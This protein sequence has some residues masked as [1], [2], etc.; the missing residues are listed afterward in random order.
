MQKQMG[1]KVLRC[2]SGHT[3]GC[4]NIVRF[5]R[6]GNTAR[7]DAMVFQLFCRFSNAPLKIAGWQQERSCGID[8]KA[9]VHT[10]PPQALASFP[11][12]N[13]F[14]RSFLNVECT[15]ATGISL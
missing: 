15:P 1:V 3:P 10:Q 14:D 12:S 9:D 4:R 2:L 11:C 7:Q 8:N 6:R 5:P 13:R